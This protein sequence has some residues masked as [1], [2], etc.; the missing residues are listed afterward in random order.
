[1][2]PLQ[3]GNAVLPK[4]IDIRRVTWR[5]NRNSD[6]LEIICPKLE[7]EPIADRPK[8]DS[9]DTPDDMGSLAA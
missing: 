2:K 9:K 4:E 7:R 5:I 3:S 8:S 6:I 1:M